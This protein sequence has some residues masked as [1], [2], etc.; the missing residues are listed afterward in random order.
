MP[1]TNLAVV[2]LLAGIVLVPFTSCTG[3]DG[4][5]G[6]P[7]ER[8]EPGPE[9]PA[10]PEG[11]MGPAGTA[12]FIFSEWLPRPDVVEEEV[13]DNNMNVKVTRLPAPELTDG[14]LDDGTVFMYIRLDPDAPTVFQLPY[15][16]YNPD[17]GPHTLGFVLEG[18]GSILITQFTHDN[19]AEVGIGAGV[20]FRYVLIP[21]GVS[22]EMAAN[23][24]N[25]RTARSY[26]GIPD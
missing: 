10:G 26:F 1:R 7:G 12:N 18:P 3:E 5:T 19:S 2:C 15:T 14:I 25:Y 23:L 20:E 24:A 17:H 6:P 21:G 9:G 4:P 8:G 11:P 22:A 16:T 13:L